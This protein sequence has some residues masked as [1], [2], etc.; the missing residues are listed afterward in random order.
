MDNFLEPDLMM[1][2]ASALQLTKP[3]LVCATLREAIISG[4]LS[5]GEHIGQQELAERLGVS[6]TPVREALRKLE[7]L[8]IVTYAPHRGSRVSVCDR[9]TAEEIYRVR[10]V[11][12]GLAVQEAVNNITENELERLDK[13]AFEV[14]PRLMEQGMHTQNFVDMRK[15][16]YEFHKVLCGASRMT[17]IPE[18]VEN[19]WARAAIPDDLFIV[20][21]DRAR[22]AV[23]EHVE[24]MQAI[25][26][27]DGDKARRLMETHIDNARLAY[28]AYLSR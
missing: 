13:L 6:A 22:M 21:S 12:E 18:I 24:V 9:Q 8:G 1:P 26:A 10:S 25:R 17:V 16:N 7:A 4:R 27:G 20:V 3:D 14:M 23:E 5:P 11:L 2:T 19:L 15:A 28:L